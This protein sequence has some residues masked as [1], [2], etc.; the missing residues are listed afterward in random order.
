MR[1]SNTTLLVTIVM[2][3]MFWLHVTYFPRAAEPEANPRGTL[4]KVKTDQ[5]KKHVAA[6][7]CIAPVR[8]E[9][10]IL[11][12]VNARLTFGP[13]RFGRRFN[14]L[15]SATDWDSRSFRRCH[16]DLRES[17]AY[18]TVHRK[19]WEWC[20]ALRLL[21][22]WLPEFRPTSKNLAAPARPLQALGVAAGTEPILYLLASRGVNVT[23]T[24]IY[25]KGTFAV[26]TNYGEVLKADTATMRRFSRG[27][28]GWEEAGKLRF[29][30]MDARGLRAAFPNA[31][32]D[33]VFSFSS[34][35]HFGGRTQTARAVQQMAHQVR[36]GG[37][38][39]LTT[40]LVV[41]G[42]MVHVE[43]P[44]SG[45]NPAEVHEFLTPGLLEEHVIAPA[46]KAGLRLIEPIDFSISR[47]TLEGAHDYIVLLEK[48]APCPLPHLL[49][50]DIPTHGGA[51]TSI[52]LAFERVV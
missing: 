48:T 31:T 15:P 36:P 40:E 27:I 18:P 47:A 21:E 43:I 2:C 22:R 41:A 7:T 30:Y 52:F 33:I 24:D 4:P 26:D 23:A 46:L 1:P 3:L 32:W 28:T 6:T 16:D 37:L 8:E 38:L 42:H 12:E 45:S 49:L 10:V 5:T 39:I 44:A 25:G 9:D 13:P 11:P 35:E 17:G 20:M 50:N 14:K 29:Q 19:L 34:I 51:Y